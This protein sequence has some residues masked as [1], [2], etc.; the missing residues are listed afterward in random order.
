MEA[1][2]I[3]AFKAHNLYV[4]SFAVLLIISATLL[5]LAFSNFEINQVSKDIENN[6]NKSDGDF[7][8]YDEFDSESSSLSDFFAK[9]DSLKIMR[10]TYHFLI[11]N[12][13][14]EY[15]EFANQNIEYQGS[16]NIPKELVDHEDV[17]LIN[18]T[19]EN[20]S[21]FTPL[22]SFQM[23]KRTYERSQ[24]ESKLIKKNGQSLYD[25]T[26]FI[27]VI[28]GSGYRSIFH[29]GSSFSGD[30]LGK[31]ATYKIIGCL[32]EQTS[33]SINNESFLLD[34]TLITPTINE[35]SE[36]DEEYLKRLYSV[37]CEGFIPYETEEEYYSVLSSL[38]M[39]KEQTGFLFYI[40]NTNSNQKH[41]LFGTL[42][43][44]LSFLTYVAL[45]VLLYKL[46]YQRYMIN[47][48]QLLVF[49]ALTILIAWLL[50]VVI[51]KIIGIEII[52]KSYTIALFI[53]VEI[54]T[55]LFR[56]EEHY[57]E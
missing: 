9:Q 51:S 4:P 11:T 31:I 21:L 34:N 19:S 14:F 44:L 12:N 38:T 27:P 26:S 8:I 36:D 39:I 50:S 48:W 53:I 32:D 5:I 25:S 3:M 23:D 52:S 2:F 7:I 24:L 35:Q 49:Q 41:S 33:I 22:K 16:L 40:P 6:I 18:Q 1:R 37:K 46:V 42:L 20:G 29:V 55:L 43:L 56:T 10:E 45:I 13:D 54:V 30:Y 15:Y 57:Y 17:D 28:M 47:K